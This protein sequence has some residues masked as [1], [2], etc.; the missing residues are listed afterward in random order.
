MKNQLKQ[1]FSESAIY[2]L[3]SIV[4]KFL[5]VALIPFYTSVLTP[6]D[7]G[8]MNLINAFFLLALMI[9]LFSLDNSS[10][11]WYYESSEESDKKKT[12]ASWF[13]FQ[14]FF[15]LFLALLF[16]LF[17]NFICEYLFKIEDTFIYYI[18]NLNFL[19][20]VLPQISINWF[21]MRRKPKETVVYT[22]SLSFLTIALT[23]YLV[24]FAD[25]G[26]LGIFLA[27]LIA[28]S[29]MSLISLF[30]LRGWLS[31]KY[32]NKVRLVEMLKFSLPLVPTALAFWMLNSSASFIIESY[33]GKAELGLFQTGITLSSG[34]VVLVFAFKM[35]FPPFAF[36]IYKNDNAKQIFSYVLTFYSFICLF[37]ALTFAL[38]SKE[39]LI[40]FTQE[41]YYPAYVVAG[42]LFFY[43]IIYGYQ[44]VVGLGNSI[45][46]DNKPTAIAVFLGAAITVLL[47]FVL[48]PQFGKEGAA[49]SMLIGYIVITI[50]VFF[51]AQ[52]RWFIPFKPL[53]S[54][55]LFV[56]A[57]ALFFTGITVTIENTF[58]SIFFRI[59]LIVIYLMVAIVFTRVFDHG[60]FMKIRDFMVNMIRKF[61]NL[62]LKS[63]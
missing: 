11:R 9:A 25:L 44:F 37:F 39:L 26:V 53:I 21:R 55:G 54:L 63:N 38:F 43:N 59:G 16:Y 4:P 57:F 24:L 40:L 17:T 22:L 3:S 27:M 13:W 61:R 29:I 41:A 62:N 50:Y 7:Y 30:L 47:F 8:L 2:G 52:K 34:I 1:L 60:L 12:I 23:V 14:L 6:E 15:T 31:A 18:A 56:I 36:S 33:Q 46:K 20:G 49:Y 51:S 45:V 35:A 10:A 19:V 42:I 48:V 28:N 5:G 58:Q 32:F